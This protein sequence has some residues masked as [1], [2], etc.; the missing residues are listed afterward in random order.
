VKLEQEVYL[1][2]FEG[3]FRIFLKHVGKKV[4][5]TS[6]TLNFTNSAQ[7]ESLS[8][9]SDKT[10]IIDQSESW[11]EL[12]LKI[13]NSVTIKKKILD[14]YPFYSENISQLLD[15]VRA[16]EEYPTKKRLDIELTFS[17]DISE[18]SSTY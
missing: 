6:V 18:L 5:A 3:Y 7:P 11:L 2:E 12:S 15:K 14:E 8:S 17:S 1:K 16:F 4:D 10:A 13:R 9:N